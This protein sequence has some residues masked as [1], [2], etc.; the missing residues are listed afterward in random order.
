MQNLFESI[1]KRLISSNE[2]AEG[3]L[4][5]NINRQFSEDGKDKDTI[6]KR[7]NAAF[8][9]ALSGTEHPL[10][11][12]AFNYLK[13]LREVPE[14]GR[15][16]GFFLKGLNYIKE[17]IDHT[18][19]ND[20]DFRRSLEDLY[21]VLKDDLSPGN[22]MKKIEAVRQVFF[23]EG[24]GICSKASEM[25]E[26]LRRRRTVKI[27]HPNPHPIARPEEEILFTSNILLT[28]PSQRRNLDSL[29]ISST[30]K[31][32]LGDV[33]KEDQL[34]WYD[35]PVQ[36]GVE[37]D[38]NEILYGLRGLSD[39]I[40]F[41]KSRG[42]VNQN[43]TINCLLSVSVTHKGLQAIAKEYIEDEFKK[44]Q[45]VDNLN[46]YIFT[47]ADTERLI[48][49]ILLPASKQ[50]LGVNSAA[51]L[52]EIFGVDG[53]YG[54]HYSFL[55]AIAA[56]W[57][58]FIDPSVRGTFKIDLDQVFPQEAL[59][60]ETGLSAFEH[61]KTPLWG[62]YGVDN[63]GDPVELG[64]LAGAL[65]NNRDIEK[66]LFTPDVCFPPEDIKADE[67]V[68]FSPL[69]QALS[70]EAEMMTRYIT[71]PLD[72]RSHCIQ[73]IHVTGG[74][75]GI[76]IDALKRYRPF[77]PTFIGRAED[78][79]YIM[80]VLFKEG[81][82]LLRYL[83]KDGLIMRHDKEAFAEEAIKSAAIGKLVGDY[84]RILWFT[85]YARALPW[86]VERIKELLDPFT[87]CF[88]SRIPLT[89]AHLRLSLKAASFFENNEKDK[90][91]ELIHIGTR[92]LNDVIE[93][94]KSKPDFV[95]AWYEREKRGWDIYY[96]TVE[97][98]EQALG[99]DDSFASKL[100]E[101]A[102]TIV[103]DCRL[104]L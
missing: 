3:F 32:Q 94:I 67:L 80:S 10:Y 24:V 40:A 103:R 37:P 62:A 58:V 41:E 60:R 1:V 70:T 89:I 6:L 31:D 92:R 52:E 72:G 78:Q 16:A 61:F 100:R 19:S 91:E 17:E 12:K 88:I 65:V 82:R 95:L 66:S 64:L 21:D 79:A 50:Y 59:V 104:R 35:H 93:R 84:I 14:F 98:V 18:Y 33:L 90:A 44:V 87:G 76:L 38:K 53:E 102:E 57:Q 29:D 4:K 27:T 46:I 77:T 99:K 30:L 49:E 5:V 11:D 101:R 39:A 15:Y 56:F 42:T 25:I 7:L 47:E 81:E 63:N 45:G 96:D 71:P 23:P 74:T 51:F 34:Y 9:V 68:F 28:I 48:E 2:C 8:L 13:N 69:P 22:R 86:R 20:S 43:A 55:K 26:E 36:I 75:T 54:R 85:F 97:A 73:R 83:H